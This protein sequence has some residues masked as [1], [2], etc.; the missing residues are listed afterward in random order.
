MSF[1]LE[2]IIES[3]DNSHN[4]QYCSP[5]KSCSTMGGL[6]KGAWTPE[7]DLRLVT[8]IHKYGHGNWRN[9]PKYAGLA[10]CGK[11]CRLRWINYLR[12][13]L[14][15]GNISKEEE[16]MIIR[17]HGL[18]GNKWSKIAACLPGRTDNEIKNVWNSHLKKRFKSKGSKPSCK[19]PKKVSNSSKS[20]CDQG[21]TSSENSKM[22]LIDFEECLMLKE[23][24]PEYTNT[25]STA[26]SQTD[27]NPKISSPS[28][29]CSKKF[30]EENKFWIELEECLTLPDLFDI[31]EFDFKISSSSLENELELC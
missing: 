27:S 20:V 30:D 17:L 26:S 16:E 1:C 9:L 31:S 24:D 23:Q 8:Y 15:R 5:H 29:S 22:V 7:E 2:N 28:F 4:P 13:G 14:K 3:T 19:K 12:P 21:N 18:L 25:S 11:S 6:K 10:R